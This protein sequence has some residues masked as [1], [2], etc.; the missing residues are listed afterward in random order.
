MLLVRSMSGPSTAPGARWGPGACLCTAFFLPADANAD[1]AFLLLAA[2]PTNP[3]LRR[4]GRPRKNRLVAFSSRHRRCRR[5]ILLVAT[6]AAA[7]VA[8]GGHRRHVAAPPQRGRGRA[9]DGELRPSG[10]TQAPRWRELRHRRRTMRRRPDVFPFFYRRAC[11]RRPHMGVGCGT[12]ESQQVRQLGQWMGQTKLG[13]DKNRD[14]NFVSL[15]IEE[16]RKKED[17]DID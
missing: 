16:K 14:G 2:T 7:V 15:L 6:G 5:W 4:P 9:V 11:E 3:I 13:P 1:V 12:A 10:L 8:G 17:I